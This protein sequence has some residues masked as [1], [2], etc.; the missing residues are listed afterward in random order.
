MTALLAACAAETDT[1]AQDTAS[2]S[3]PP[4]QDS[5]EPSPP[6]YG[7]PDDFTR[8]LFNEAPIEG[9]TPG[10]DVD[11]AEPIL[12]ESF[13]SGGEDA[14]DG[15]VARLYATDGRTILLATRF[16]L[17]DDSI[18]SLQL[19]AEFVPISPLQ[20]SLEFTGVRQKCARGADTDS[21]TTQPCP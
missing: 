13:L 8:D 15:E 20:T 11:V 2:L 19:Y 3:S 1:P 12:R 7:S 9:L 10:M 17:A 5:V 16:G 21:W 4:S 14:G 18:D 6:G